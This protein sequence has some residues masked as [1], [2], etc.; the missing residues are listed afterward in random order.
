MT[1]QENE[2]IPYNEEYTTFDLG[3]AGALVSAGYELIGLDKTYFKKANFVFR[4]NDKID[5]VVNEYWNNELMVNARAYF[6]NIKMLKNRLH[7]N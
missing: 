6:D 5:L 1:H 2:Y 3:L 4:R 7:S